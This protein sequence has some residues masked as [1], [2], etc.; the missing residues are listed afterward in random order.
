MERN[1]KNHIFALLSTAF[2]FAVGVGPIATH[3]GE[4]V[5]LIEGVRTLTVGTD[6]VDFGNRTVDVHDQVI[7]GI[8]F[9]SGGMIVDDMDNSTASWSITVSADDFDDETNT[10]SYEELSI[11]GDDDNTIEVTD[12]TSNTDGLTLLT[13]YT[14][15]SGTGAQSDDITLLSADSR[16]RVAE[17]TIHP[18]MKLTIPGGT[19][20]GNY[21]NTLT[22]T[23][24][25]N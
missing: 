14:N 12:G 18:E 13:A 1:I 11:I 7:S 3:A 19:L 22:I 8:T 16:S 24:L 20:A 25:V 6:T 9:D 10:I 15:F 4:L 2:V 21:E 17:Y 5:V 23:F